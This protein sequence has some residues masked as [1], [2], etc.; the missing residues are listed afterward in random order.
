MFGDWGGKRDRLADGG[1]T[2][3]VNNIGDFLADVASFEIGC[4][5]QHTACNGVYKVGIAL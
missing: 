1:V 3:N 5:E 2:L 4:Q